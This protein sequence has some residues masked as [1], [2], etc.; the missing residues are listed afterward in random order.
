M[1]SYR[2][3]FCIPQYCHTH[4][5][6]ME[7]VYYYTGRSFPLA[8]SRRTDFKHNLAESI[9][10]KDTNNVYYAHFPG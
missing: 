2:G 6:K 7:G 10:I 1:N 4:T 5:G 3:K 8:G 9:I